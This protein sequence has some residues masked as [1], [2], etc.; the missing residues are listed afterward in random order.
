MTGRISYMGTKHELAATVREVVQN[1]QP[2]LLL[3][4]FAG[5]GAIAESLA[6][7]RNVWTNDVQHFAHLA[8]SCRLAD[9]NGPLPVRQISRMARPLFKANLKALLDQNEGALRLER[10]A[11]RADDF[12]AFSTPLR[13]AS[14][15]QPTHAD[16]YGCFT[17]TYSHGYFSLEQSAEIDSIRYSLEIL[18]GQ[19]AVTSAQFRWGILA[20][21]AAILRIANTTGHFAQYLTPSPQN[22]RRVLKQFKR[23]VWHEWGCIPFPYVRL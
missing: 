15:I 12:E 8:T 18:R 10:K 21:G 9:E 11:L 22:Y 1:C 13:E 17:K 2:G 6:N 5:M 19:G 4:A 7:D 16:A 20:L 3:D 14:M 23:R